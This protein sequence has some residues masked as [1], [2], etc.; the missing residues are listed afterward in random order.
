MR[1]KA[2][3]PALLKYLLYFFLFTITEKGVA[4]ITC[5]FNITGNDTSCAPLLLQASA[6]EVSSSTVVERIWELSGPIP[7]YTTTPG[8]NN[9]LFY[10][11]GSK[12]G[13]YCLKL[14]SKNA[15][16]EVST[17]QKCNIYIA[18][19]PV[20][21]MSLTSVSG[22]APILASATYFRCD[23]SA[24]SG[25]IN[26]FQLDWGCGPVYTSSTC[27]PVPL[28]KLYSSCPPGYY[29]PT[30]VVYNSF[31][32]HTET[33]FT[34]AVHITPKPHAYF[35]A[36]VTTSNCASGPLNVNFTA[37]PAGQTCVTYNWY[38]NNV[39]KYSDTTGGFQYVFPISVN[40]YDIKLVVRNCDGCSDSVERLDYV[41][42]RSTPQILY[43]V[44]DSSVCITA[45]TPF[46][47]ILT[48]VSVAP[49]NLTW[50][51]TGPYDST[52]FGPLASFPLSTPGNYSVEITGTFGP[53]CSSTI[54]KL[55][56]IVVKQKPVVD[57][58]TTDVFSCRIPYTVQ[59]TTSGCSTCTYS[60]A[61]N[62][63]SP[64]NS[65]GPNP[66]VTYN[67]YN[68]SFPVI[69]TATDANGCTASVTH[70][71]VTT[72]K[73][74]AK[75]DF[76]KS[77]A[78][79]PLCTYF[80]D[81]TN[82]VLV[83]STI[84]SGAA[85][86]YIN[87]PAPIPGGCKDS[88]NRCFTVPGCY[89]ITLVVTTVSG[90]RD[91]I[92]L[93]DTVCVGL[94]PQC[95]MT[96]SPATLCFE[97]DSVNFV[98]TCNTPPPPG[99][100]RCHCNFDDGNEA[101]FY[102]SSFF[103]NY[104]DTIGA[105]HPSCVAYN[106][107]C[108]SDTFQFTIT[109]LPPR[110]KFLDSTFCS[111]GDTIFL[112]NKTIGA[113]SY[114]WTFCDG[115]TSTLANPFIIAPPCDTCTIMLHSYN[116]VSGCDLEKGRTIKTACQSS[117][118]SP[119]DSG[120][121]FPGALYFTNTSSSSMPGFTRWDFDTSDGVAWGFGSPG[122]DA[123]YHSFP[124]PGI[125]NIAMR[126]QTNSYCIDT[127]Y[128]SVHICSDTA[129]FGPL[130]VCLP[131]AYCPVDSSIDPYCN[132]IDWQ[133]DF[134][135][136]TTASGQNP[137]HVFT[138]QGNKFVKL[139][140]TSDQGCKDSITKQIYA[141][142]NIQIE[143]TIDTL[144]CEGS[145]TCITNTSVSNLEFNWTLQG[146]T[147]AAS[148]DYSPCF[149][150]PV[151][152]GD[153]PLHLTISAFGLCT[154]NDNRVIHV[155]NPVAGGYANNTTIPCPNPPQITYFFDTS[156][157]NDG[158]VTWEFGDG[159]FSN[160]ANA[161]HIYSIPGKYQV[162]IRDST[163]DGCTDTA[164]IDVVVVNGPYGSLVTNPLV[165]CSCQ[166]S[167]TFTVSTYDASAFTLLYGCNV[168]FFRDT[169][170][171]PIG[172]LVNPTI[173]TTSW[174]FCSSDS[175]Q[176][177]IIFE[178]STGCQV[179][180]NGGYIVVDSPVVDFKIDIHKDCDY[181]TV[182]F[183]DSTT[184]HLRPDQSFTTR[185][186]WDFGDSSPNRYDSLDQNPCHFYDK[187]GDYIAKF[188]IWSNLG[189][190]DS[191][192][193]LVMI[194]GVPIAGYYADDSVVCSNDPLCFHDSS[195][196]YSRT[197]PDYWIWNWGDGKI[198]TTYASDI[199]HTFTAGGYYRV[200][201][202]VYDSL[203]CPGSD[204]SSI[205]RVFFN[206]VADYSWAASCEDEQMPLSSTS[207]TGDAPISLCEW[208]LWVGAAL[209]LLDSNCNTAFQFPPGLHDVQLVVRDLNGCRDTI[210][211]TLLTD[212]LSELFVN[213]GDT[214]ICLGVSVDYTA[215]GVFD[216]IRWT[217]GAWVS[218]SNSPTVN[219]KAEGDIL[220]VV[221]AI[222]G[223]CAAALDTVTILINQPVPLV[224]SATP[225][226]IVLGLE[227]NLR[228][229]YP[230]I[231]DSVVWS[232]DATLD[233]R[234]CDNPIAKPLETTTYTATAYKSRNGVVCSSSGSVT[235][236]V[237]AVCD[238]RSVYVPNTFTPNGD[239]LNDLFMIR[240]LPVT[241]INYLR[242][243]D[244]WGKMVFEAQ[245]GEANES[246]WGWNGTDMQGQKLNPAVF[247]YTYEVECI[248]HDIFSGHG[249]VTLVK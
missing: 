160:L 220:Y 45:G 166:D 79:G 236:D 245:N 36:N 125:Y 150:F 14:T 1:M 229:T 216:I 39:L 235:I 187:V 49:P 225:D 135:D 73:L 57:F 234:I 183:F 133:W 18:A 124:A 173:S 118:L 96:A 192:S 27:P 9:P 33:T 28:T 114:L 103:H 6:V 26:S 191:A 110:T 77:K 247:V 130:S 171:A 89:D 92:T 222:N 80:D 226:H 202:S 128:T 168:G 70:S 23:T 116:N 68:P 90:C 93:S 46:N 127:V 100:Q 184:Y 105:F 40:C 209:P 175:C 186:L 71:L 134:G 218:D 65:T 126:N 230:S 24:G 223:V 35:S 193:Y 180:L 38:V 144:I 3:T 241:R 113:T 69:L 181:G 81:I 149:Q 248:N 219:I 52:Q 47:F 140:I 72:R 233:C 112:Y 170:I 78:C 98:L 122:G 242:I 56:V 137:C 91:S 239:G 61:M 19:N 177:Q 13:N 240:G 7:T 34:H 97:K 106:D 119:V 211:K 148:T 83:N 232:P 142:S 20:L 66:V 12:P 76:N 146:A 141:T 178:D 151:G 117:S 102:T 95:T 111:S 208:T 161:T 82:P 200:K 143:Y 169:P 62:S 213:P 152:T 37:D 58:T 107:S 159:G 153:Y 194:P 210:V 11:L 189:C 249:N 63:A 115:T 104:R 99:F 31:G 157:Y 120:G 15:N 131:L 199:C 215:T 51:L 32:C 205:I 75:I 227:S 165:T 244:R 59:Y 94:P 185:F 147:P 174:K 109:I 145:G 167:V 158:S 4:A 154:V 48:N 53:G 163:L 203:G 206:P 30:V 129:N 132:I 123:V 214:T 54:N 172:T 136:G 182:C 86:W 108:P 201:M 21:N 162:L 44:N 212:S 237:L 121:C 84:D 85:C 228:A 207:V 64:N 22:C 176:P 217:P 10:Y 156:R 67:S 138:G 25:V 195:W 16:G 60:W 197:K 42:V 188:Y 231:I 139:V 190:Y 29:N 17:I 224:V 2:A 74:Q 41:C 204:S 221:S 246:K 87:G 55:N 243:F 196:I 50:H 179:F 8:G 238:G 198:D 155:H 43:T 5:A 88:I 101:D 164:L